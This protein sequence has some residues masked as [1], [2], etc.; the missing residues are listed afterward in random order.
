MSIGLKR[1][2]FRPRSA[3]GSMLNGLR[4]KTLPN[5][6]RRCAV[7]AAF[8]A[9]GS[10]QMQEPRQESRALMPQ[11]RTLACAR[12]G[13]GEQMT[14]TAIVKRMAAVRGITDSGCPHSFDD[15][16]L[17]QI[18]VTGERAPPCTFAGA[19]RRPL[20]TC[21]RR[22]A[23]TCADGQLYRASPADYWIPLEGAAGLG[24]RL[25]PMGGVIACQPGMCRGVRRRRMWPGR[26]TCLRAR[27]SASS[28]ASGCPREIPPPFPPP[29]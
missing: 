13:D 18:V 19:I 6:A 16:R 25:D 3:S 29:T 12:G 15:P 1:A 17:P 22:C 2:C 7:T 27:P 10:M 9:L 14:G 11:R 26:C 21:F 20:Y 23:F 4:M 24:T 5:R 28:G 8:S